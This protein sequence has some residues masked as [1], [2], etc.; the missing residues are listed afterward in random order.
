MTSI[1]ALFRASDE[2]Q[3]LYYLCVKGKGFVICGAICQRYLGVQGRLDI[4]GK[5]D[6]SC[7]R[8]NGQAKHR[9]QVSVR[10]SRENCMPLET[11]TMS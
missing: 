6:I 1:L 10:K 7:S 11:L 4:R 9:R 8:E 3:K 5:V 2:D